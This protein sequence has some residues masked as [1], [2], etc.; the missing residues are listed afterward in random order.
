MRSGRGHAA[1]GG[2]ATG[3]PSQ[4][5]SAGATERLQQYRL[6][7]SASSHRVEALSNAGPCCSCACLLEALVL[8]LTSTSGCPRATNTSVCVSLGPNTWW[9]QNPWF[10]LRIAQS[11]QWDLDGDVIEARVA[12]PTEDWVRALPSSATAMRKAANRASR[13]AGRRPAAGAGARGGRAGRAG[14]GGQ[15]LGFGVTK[16]LARDTL[17]ADCSADGTSCLLSQPPRARSH[18]GVSHSA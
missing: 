9:K 4:L 6:A 12:V 11:R 14:L 15:R 3:G 8:L 10:L 7:W 13:L 16:Y 1:R 18:S 17:Q 2:A 5:R